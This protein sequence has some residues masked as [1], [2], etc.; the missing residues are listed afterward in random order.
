MIF[1]LLPIKKFYRYFGDGYCVEMPTDPNQLDKLLMFLCEQNA[2][3]K[4]YATLSNG[5]WFHGMHIA[6][7]K[8]TD[9]DSIIRQV[10]KLLGIVSYC[11]VEGGTQT[12]VDTSDNVLSFADFTE[13]HED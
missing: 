2:Q 12:I 4:F 7:P 13:R 5:N 11:V 10:C 1:E 6:F 3:W 8:N 9:T